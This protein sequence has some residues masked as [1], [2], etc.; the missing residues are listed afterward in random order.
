MVN[1]THQRR[2]VCFSRFVQCGW[3]YAH[4]GS[5]RVLLQDGGTPGGEPVCSSLTAAIS[6]RADGRELAESRSQKKRFT[7]ID[8]YIL[9]PFHVRPWT[10]YA[11]NCGISCLDILGEVGLSICARSAVSRHRRYSWHLRSMTAEAC[12]RSVKSRTDDVV[13]YSRVKDSS[14]GRIVPTCCSPLFAL[15][16]RPSCN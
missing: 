3:L 9:L 10:Y 4:Q 1:Y 14:T 16:R 5:C 12:E 2:K 13:Q 11:K 6:Q 8:L 15:P 7:R